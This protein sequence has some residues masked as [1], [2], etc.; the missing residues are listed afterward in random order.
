[1]QGTF[2][3]ERKLRTGVRM[4]MAHPV[5]HLVHW[6]PASVPVLAESLHPGMVWSRRHCRTRSQPTR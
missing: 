2:G 3:F 6:N 5:C 1:M 4:S